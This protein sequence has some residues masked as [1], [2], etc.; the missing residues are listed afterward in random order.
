M[1]TI[2][3]TV[4]NTPTAGDTTL[5]TPTSY[6]HVPNYTP[7][8]F[9]QTNGPSLVEYK[10]NGVTILHLDG[11]LAKALAQAQ[12]EMANARKD[13]TN[14][15]FKSKYADLAA[16]W[17][18]CRDAL[19]KF[20]LSVTQPL[21][22]DENGKIYLT[23][24]LMHS[25]GEMISSTIP[26]IS[27]KPDPQSIGSAITYFKRFA[28]MA[29]VGVTSSDEVDDDGHEASDRPAVQSPVKPKAAPTPIPQQH[30]PEIATQ[31]QVKKLFALARQIGISD[32]DSLKA[33]IRQ[34][35]S[36]N[37]FSLAHLSQEDYML[38]LKKLESSGQAVPF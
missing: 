24:I 35:T 21:S 6:T 23:T 8:M 38:I 37:E 14:P 34:N 1:T 28:L 32:K 3:G 11:S 27:V 22:T 26:V 30:E 2:K 4:T 33:W 7:P 18:A 36:L 15:F 12:G 31:D 10:M 13:K 5:S 9:T 29:V 25:S 19:S 20:E 16:V 17:D